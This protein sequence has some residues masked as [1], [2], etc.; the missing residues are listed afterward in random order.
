MIRADFYSVCCE[1]HKVN[2]CTGLP[3][4]LSGDYSST[5]VWAC[6]EF[7]E[8]ENRSLE[9]DVHSSNVWKRGPTPPSPSFSSFFFSFLPECEME[10]PAPARQPHIPP[11]QMTSRVPPPH[12]LQ[13][14]GP[15]PR[16]AD[17]AACCFTCLRFHLKKILLWRGFELDHHPSQRP[18]THLH[19]PDC[20]NLSLSPYSWNPSKT[21]LRCSDWWR[22]VSICDRFN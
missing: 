3:L 13:H 2:K 11:L 19:T 8:I 9:R 21:R 17:S 6:L 16:P 5:L 4:H 18:H 20:P 22:S 7:L 10:Y 14:Y 1:I 15:K 12:L